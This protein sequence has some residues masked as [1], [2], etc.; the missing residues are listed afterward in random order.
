MGIVAAL[1]IAL[2]LALALPVR[3]ASLDDGRLSDLLDWAVQLS[4]RPLPAGVQRP[5]IERLGSAELAEVVCGGDAERCRNVVA[6]YDTGRRRIVYLDSLDMAN[7]A[8]R[9][10]ILH[11]LVHYLQ[12]LQ[13]GDDFSTS[14][15]EAVVAS[16]REAYRVQNKYLRHFSQGRRVGQALWFTHCDQAPADGRAARIDTPH[17]DPAR[18]RQ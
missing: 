5:P 18:P 10:F 17:A 12:H 11:E 15:C 2:A 1:A 7:A 4:G 16:E 9:S 8:D 13:R 6:A 3:A 14:G